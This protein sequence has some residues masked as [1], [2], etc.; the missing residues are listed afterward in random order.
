[1]APNPPGCDFSWIS[2]QPDLRTE[3]SV[4]GGGRGESPQQH[5]PVMTPT[6]KQS[7][8]RAERYAFDCSRM[9]GEQGDL[10]KRRRIIEPATASRVPSGEYVVSFIVPFP[11]RALAPSGN[12]NRV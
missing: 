1:M 9:P 3:S 4:S 12:S 2:V 8:I 6:G 11:S 10:L 7:P 5:R